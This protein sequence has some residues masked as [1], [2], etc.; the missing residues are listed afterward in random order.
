MMLHRTPR[1]MIAALRGGAGKTLVSTGLAAVF[2]R[3]KGLRVAVF[4]KG[5]DYIDAGWLGCA[6]A[7]S[8]Y[9]LDPYMMPLPDLLRSFVDRAAG[10]DV[11]VIEGNRGLYDGV[12][13]D[14]TCASAELAKLLK[15]P[16][17]LVLDAT[18]V[19]RT[20]AAMILG[21]QH[22][23]IQVRV[24]GVILNRVAGGRHERV[25]TESI[26]KV[27]DVPVLGALPKDVGIAFPERHMGLVPVHEHAGVQRTL[28]LLAECMLR[29]VDVEAL[30]RIAQAAEPL[31]RPAA[32]AEGRRPRGI[33]R[34][35]VRIGVIQ[36]RVFQFYYPE[37]LEALQEA[38]AELVFVDSTRAPV[39]PE[40]DALYI[41]GGFPETHLS[42]LVANE[43]FRASVRNAVEDGLPVYAEC[44]GLMYL[45][46]GIRMPEG[47]H[48]MVGVL[49]FHVSMGKRP[50]GH[51][52]T[53]VEVVGETPFFPR[54]IVLKGHEF[55]YSRVVDVDGP[56]ALAFRVKKGC[57][58]LEGQDGVCYRNVLAT[59]TH[60][61]AVGCQTWAP[62]LVGAGWRY[63]MARERKEVS[64]LE[65]SRALVG[66]SPA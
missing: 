57:G 24:A 6:A 12:D 29:Y 17:V 30:H 43:S 36:D 55:H 19:T 13:A 64:G 50:Q 10:T 45:S 66:Q 49:P 46:R 4:K 1:L 20:A 25:L 61:H 9:N 63:R 37:N 40:L 8:C 34:P 7:S 59:Y 58:V 15:A 44:G 60:L 65:A 23:D 28:D 18:K 32:E 14:G 5:P 31:G 39:L 16:V 35:C 11:A 26:E 41:G 27:C 48:P 53:I 3:L 62:G 54:G 22:L 21:C 38:G 42:P 51:G 56:V 47:L 33:L 52:Y 2:R